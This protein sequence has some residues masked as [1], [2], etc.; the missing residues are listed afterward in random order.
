MRAGYGKKL[1]DYFVTHTQPIQLL[2]MGP[3]VFDAT[4]D[5]NILL[6]QNGAAWALVGFD[7]VTIGIDFD[8]QT[9]NISRYLSDNGT[10]MEMPKKGDPWAILS[11]TE[12]NLKRKIEDVG[13]PLKDW[14]IN[15]NYGIKTGYNTAFVINEATREELVAQDPKS[16]EIIKPLLRG[17]DIKRYYA[18]PAGFYILATDYDLDIPNQYPA[19]YI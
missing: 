17:K 6:L 19:I 2:D 14:D 10:T 1:R 12:L 16:A 7:A 13:V 9:D 5:T 15:I 4:V 8:K 3:D 11:S 18:R